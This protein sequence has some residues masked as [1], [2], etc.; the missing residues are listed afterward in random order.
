MASA[1]SLYK[2]IHSSLVSRLQQL[3]SG[4]L[5]SCS[6]DETIKIWDLTGGRCTKTLFGHNRKVK[7]M[8][9]NSLNSTLVS[10]SGER[11]IKGECINT[12][13][14]LNGDQLKDLIFI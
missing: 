2:V 4:Q 10:C 6:S 7:S 13:A 1:L 5:I 12:I 11:V 3:E 14:V 8:R 9:I